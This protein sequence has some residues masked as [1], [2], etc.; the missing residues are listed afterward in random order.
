MNAPINY[1]YIFDDQKD[2][3]LIQ[4]KEVLSDLI[5][6]STQNP[7]ITTFNSLSQ[8]EDFYNKSNH[9]SIQY[10]QSLQETNTFFEESKGQNVFQTSSSR[11]V[12]NPELLRILEEELFVNE[13][14]RFNKTKGYLYY[15]GVPAE[16]SGIGYIIKDGDLK[17]IE[18]F[19]G[20]IGKMTC[21]QIAYYSLL[22]GIQKAQSIGIKNLECLGHNELIINQ[23]TGQFKVK[24]HEIIT[25]FQEVSLL[26]SSFGDISFKKISKDDNC[27]AISLANSVK[28]K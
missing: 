28:N 26:K 11:K 14:K 9:L 3:R 4:S 20:S 7:K 12:Q 16:R 18:E 17:I 27:H 6:R 19:R 10:K 21:N 22:A 8:A 1:A 23:L 5:L 25:I 15:A 24:D 13:E 2:M